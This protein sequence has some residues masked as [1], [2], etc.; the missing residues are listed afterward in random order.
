MIKYL[1]FVA[2]VLFTISNS[3]ASRDTAKQPNFV[4]LISEDN[5][6]HYLSIYS[7]KGVNTPNIASIAN[8]GVIFNQ[9]FANS[10]VCSTARSTLALGV[11]APT[12]YQQHHR[13][14][15]ISQLNNEVKPLSQL[16]AEAGYYTTNKSKEDYNFEKP[17]GTWH[18]SSKQAH[19]SKRA[20]RQ[21]FF[22]V[23]SFATTHESRLH[24]PASDLDDKPI[25]LAYPAGALLPKLPE[26][27]LLKYTYTRYLKQHQILDKQIGQVLE[28][29]KHDQLLD[30]TFVFYFGDHGGAL[31]GSKG[32]LTDAGLSVP[33]LLHIPKN[34]RDKVDASLLAKKYS[35]KAISFVDFAP[36][37]LSLAGIKAQPYHQGQDKLSTNSEASEHMQFYYADRF[38]EKYDLARALRMG[39]YKYVR[40]FIPY[41]PNSLFNNYRYKQAAYRELKELHQNAQLPSAAERFFQAKEP[42]LLFDTTA[43][44]NELTNLAGSPK[45]RQQLEKMRK[46]LTEKMMQSKDLAWFPESFVLTSGMLNSGQLRAKYLALSQQLISLTDMQNRS[47]QVSKPP[48]L[49]AL[50]SNSQWLRYWAVISLGSLSQNLDAQIITRLQALLQNDPSEYVQARAFE[51]LAA[52][53]VITNTDHWQR[54][55]Q[56]ATT[57]IRRLE[58]LNIATYLFEQT[59]L[60]FAQ[61]SQVTAVKKQDRIN[62]KLVLFWLNK[63]WQYLSSVSAKERSASR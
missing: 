19:W 54:L 8:T 56:N 12:L 35:N 29:L 14:F 52:Q 50:K 15:A 38:D 53:G 63:R 2:F 27:P 3:A 47:Y 31:P 17:I 51:V 59:K 45:L 4:W 34:F 32:Y 28:Q 24:F 1:T 44:P 46:G 16:L 9:A 43:D 26:T 36:S 40:N 49:Q 58:L 55:Y 60:T 39:K 37:V 5:A 33:L 57:N 41:Y 61:P 22:H 42:E 62:N 21:P 25:D 7:D 11:Y 30:D 23:Q 10:P 18:D 48:L 13:S 6:K 20:D